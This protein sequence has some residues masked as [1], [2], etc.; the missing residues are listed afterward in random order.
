MFYVNE[1]SERC[2]Y[3]TIFVYAYDFGRHSQF[4][5]HLCSRVKCVGVSFRH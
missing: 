5:L 2:I 4:A 1:Q 3:D